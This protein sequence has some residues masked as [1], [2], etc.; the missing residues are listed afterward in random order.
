ML[1]TFGGDV[2]LAIAAYNAGP[3]AVKDA[4]N[5]VPNFKETQN[6][7][8]KV[9]DEYERLKK[10]QSSGSGR[11]ISNHTFYTVKSGKEG[12]V[13]SLT[14]DTWVKLQ[15]L[16]AAFDRQFGGEE[17]YEPFYVTAGGSESGH[18]PGSKHYS[19]EAFDIAMDSLKRHP[20]R[21]KW[22]EENAPKYGLKPLNEY[23]GYGNE[24]YADG[25]NFHFSNNG[26]PAN[27]AAISAEIS[28]SGGGGQWIEEEVSN[29]NPEKWKALNDALDR[30]GQYSTASKNQRFSN[31]LQEVLQGSTGLT[32]P[33]E[34]EALAQSV[35]QKY[36]LTEQD[37]ST[38][39]E[40]SLGNRV[41]KQTSDQQ[42]SDTMAALSLENASY[43][44][45]ER[46]YLAWENAH[47]DAPDSEKQQHMAN[48][49]PEFINRNLKAAARAASKSGGAEWFKN[50][51]KKKV[52]NN[53]IAQNQLKGEQITNAMDII[54]QA[55]QKKGAPLTEKEITTEINKAS[56]EKVIYEGKWY[57]KT[58]RGRDVDYS[59]GNA[60]YN[61]DGLR[62]DN[63]DGQEVLSDVDEDDFE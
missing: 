13:T 51:Y 10:Q 17:D 9:M 63:E 46:E 33:S 1:D 49:S 20:E 52:F 31:A 37:I 8:V 7:V 36:N 11:T 54:T 18:N 26:T 34:C 35:G 40:A 59:S 43:H 3:Q 61:N 23:N 57:E 28:Q 53:A 24:Q 32:L 45:A 25:E 42:R 29:Y 19:M 62:V 4:G 30:Q 39:Y 21:F 16:A 14:H 55:E 15:G 27:E 58:I 6:H 60:G 50:P 41:N 48:C 2:R 47:M 56:A 44:R 38:L 12:E 5:Q 22:L